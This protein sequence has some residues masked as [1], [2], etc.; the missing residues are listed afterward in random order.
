MENKQTTSHSTGI[1]NIKFMVLNEGFAA[2]LARKNNTKVTYSIKLELPENDEAVQHLSKVSP[3]KIVRNSDGTVTINFGSDF[4]VPVVDSE[5][6]ELKGENIPAFN[7]LTDSGTAT[8]MYNVITYGQKTIVRL[9]GVKLWKLDLAPRTNTTEGKSAYDI[10]LER[11]R[12]LQ[13]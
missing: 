8:A 1:G 3:K 10:N 11:L 5:D 13:G 9:S 4:M 6:N 7:G 2:A 12:G